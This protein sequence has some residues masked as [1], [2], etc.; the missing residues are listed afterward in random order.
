MSTRDD[1]DEEIAKK[2]ASL[3]V[4]SDAQMAEKLGLTRGAINQWRTRGR[5]PETARQRVESFRLLGSDRLAAQDRAKA[6]GSQLMF[7]GRCLALFLAPS[8]DA[9]ATRRIAPAHYEAQWREYAD[10]FERI[11]LACADEIAQRQKV[12]EGTPADALADL[13]KDDPV[14][15]LERIMDRARTPMSH[16]AHYL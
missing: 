12:I 10:L 1:L 6:L 15:L 2:R 14:V 13:T 3:G 16:Y 9:L 5:V 8:R 7:E 11:C 4:S